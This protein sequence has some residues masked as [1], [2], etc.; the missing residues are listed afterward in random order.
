MIQAPVHEHLD[1]LPLLGDS[2]SSEVL[3]FS[4]PFAPRTPM[5][6]TYPNYTVS[7]P[8]NSLADPP[9][10]LPEFALIIAPVSSLTAQTTLTSCS[11][12]S[13]ASSGSEISRSLWLRDAEG[14]RMQWLI[15]DL[16]PWTNYTAYVVQNNTKV[17]GPIYFSTKSGMQMTLERLMFALTKESSFISLP[18]SILP[19]VLPLHSLCSPSTS[20]YLLCCV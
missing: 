13:M 10:S 19:T 8:N 7:S 20:S 12:L 17:S 4:P 18:D 6:P 11:L 9:E 16:L 5:Q 14:W 15:G 2:T 1:A 3:I